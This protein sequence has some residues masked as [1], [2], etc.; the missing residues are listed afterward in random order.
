MKQAPRRKSPFIL[1]SVVAGLSLFGPAALH[2]AAFARVAWASQPTAAPTVEAKPSGIDTIRV[3]DDEDKQVSRME[4]SIRGFQ[5]PG[6]VGPIVYMVSAVHVAD[7]SFYTEM[8]TFLD[9]QDLVLFEG[10][11]PAGTGAMAATATD[12]QRAT[13]TVNRMELL[14]GLIIKRWAASGAPPESI[15]SL[16]EDNK[17]FASLLPTMRLDGW[18]KPIALETIEVAGEATKL[19]LFSAAASAAGSKAVEVGAVGEQ[20]ASGKKGEAVSVDGQS[21]LAM[22]IE[23]PAEAK[24]GKR[25]KGAKAA[26]NIQAQLAKAL[27][28]TY[29]LDGMDSSKPN[30]RASDMSI[31]E[32]QTR[33]KDAG[34]D[35]SALFSMLDGSSIPARFAGVVLGLVGQSK[36]MST[37]MKGM[38]LDVLTMGDR[39]FDS[40]AMQSGPMAKLGPAM[41]VILHD[42]NDV[43]FADIK[44]VVANE[45]DMKT[46][47]AF[48]GAAHMPGLEG[49]L[50]GELGMV[51]ISE[52]WVPAITVDPKDA[53]TTL[54]ALKAQRASTRKMFENQLGG[55]KA[56]RK[57]KPAGNGDAGKPDEPL[58]DKPG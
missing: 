51:Q 14:K 10:V 50:K 40:P 12:E 45:P 44:G 46:I 52:R 54:K 57:A 30:W 31:D 47:A 37:T 9:K 35:A 4:L 55:E 15:D 25:A 11:K 56:P 41:K 38:M 53:G 24:G 21:P 32:L 18:G 28:L 42:R 58:A 6:G 8:Q 23:Q 34:G 36:W 48:Y 43:V 5:K 33:I 2:N 16:A 19:R 29:Q 39:A 1:S 7:K 22:T 13:A 49:M 27:G 26:P 3:V 20:P 17:R